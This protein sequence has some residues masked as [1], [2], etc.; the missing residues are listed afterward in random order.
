MA[1]ISYIKAFQDNYFWKITEGHHCL[2]VDPGDAQP[3]IDDVNAC[4]QTIS[5]ILV[6]HHH[7]DHI[8]GVKTLKSQFQCPVYGPNREASQVVDIPLFEGD[9]IRPEG[10]NHEFQIFEVPGHTLGHISYFADHLQALFCGD[11]LFAGGCGRL[12]EGTAAQMLAS[13]KK[14]SSLPPETKVYCAH[15]YTLS[16]L[17]FALTIE[18]DNKAL[19][20]RFQ[21]IK[22]MRSENMST[23]P[24]LLEDELATNPFLRTHSSNIK[25]TLFAADKDEVG[26]FAQIRALK[27][28]F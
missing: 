10:S 21:K 22:K 13:L 18:P 2:I 14:L 4:N 27:D 12:F 25:E 11:T 26:I 28:H 5:A 9:K 16:N 3:V 23:V 1:I 6:T 20:T 19:V 24:S 15:E 8:G 17:K 7:S